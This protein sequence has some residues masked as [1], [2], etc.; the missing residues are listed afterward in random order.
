MT[1]LSLYIF[2]VGV[3]A[4]LAF[5]HRISHS[6]ARMSRRWVSNSS[7]SCA[8]GDSV[9]I[10]GPSG[11]GKGTL[12]NRLLST[13]PNIF[14]LSVSHT[15]RLPRP[16]EID[17]YHYHFRSLEYL[18]N[19]IEN[20]IIPYIEHAE[21][22]GNLYGTRQDAVDSIHK[23][24]K[25]CILDLDVK[26]VQQ[27]KALGFSAHYIFLTPPSLQ[28]LEDRLRGRHTESEESIQLRLANAR[29]ELAYG[30]SQGVFNYV[31]VN[32]H[33]DEAYGE[34]EEIMKKW[35]PAYFV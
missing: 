7:R 23:H 24:H 13:H 29:A 21:V 27:L 31:L 2:I 3:M 17:G 4:Y 16:G 33:M 6:L 28:D 35:L 9:V 5:E 22:H 11:S 10:C 25:V 12:I 1:L 14:A 15:S 30:Q 18:K 20:G 26:G 8:K 34:L 19:D 32:R